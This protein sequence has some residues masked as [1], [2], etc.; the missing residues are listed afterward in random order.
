MAERRERREER[1]GPRE[2]REAPQ[3]GHSGGISAWWH[4]AP[5]WQKGAVVAGAGVA[6]FLIYKWWSNRSSSSTTAAAATPSPS[7]GSGQPSTTGG[8]SGSGGGGGYPGYPFWPF[9]FPPPGGGGGT[10][11]NPAS[12]PVTVPTSPV[13]APTT[14]TTTSPAPATAPAVT[15]ATPGAISGG[16]G[17]TRAAPVR[18]AVAPSAFTT[19]GALPEVNPYVP[20]ASAYSRGPA[21]EAFNP[22]FTPPATLSAYTLPPSSTQERHLNRVSQE[23]FG[24]A[25]PFP[26]TSPVSSRPAVKTTKKVTVHQAAPKPKPR[27]SVGHNMLMR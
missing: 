25:G 18:T 1:R 10:S 20:P 24:V 14:T 15:A 5:T 11:G 12:P 27:T 2:R 8:G 22:A 19:T 3:G 26:V 13:P 9:P 23:Q 4:R 7:P 16:T 21:T 17:G 6:A